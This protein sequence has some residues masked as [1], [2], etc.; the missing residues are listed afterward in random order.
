VASKMQPTMGY[1]VNNDEL[2]IW[3]YVYDWVRFAYSCVCLLIDNP[4][5][6]CIIV[7]FINK[8]TFAMYV[9]TPSFCCFPVF[10][11]ILDSF[12]YLCFTSTYSSC[13]ILR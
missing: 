10:K 13:Y 4:K 1:F 8:V 9:A 5:K 12:D 7:P 6:E 3:P 11:K 2:N